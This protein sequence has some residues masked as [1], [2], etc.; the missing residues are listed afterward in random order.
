MIQ[1]RYGY[2]KMKCN[3]GTEKDILNAIRQFTTATRNT[4]SKRTTKKNPRMQMQMQIVVTGDSLLTVIVPANEDHTGLM[5]LLQLVIDDNCGV[6]GYRVKNVIP[7]T[8]K[9][10]THTAHTSL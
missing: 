4:L 10:T 5:N 2:G 7:Y 8:W 3:E 9:F 1:D 6:E